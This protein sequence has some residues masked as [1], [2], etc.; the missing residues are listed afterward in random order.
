MSTV[1]EIGS[2]GR[3]D[4]GR[5][6]PVPARGRKRYPAMDTAP[7]RELKHQIDD[8]RQDHEQLLTA[9]R[10]TRDLVYRLEAELRALAH[11]LEDHEFARR[12]VHGL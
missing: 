12:G 6:A 3:R 8:L 5:E 2:G 4:L 9:F 1:A 7:L 11:R 10:A